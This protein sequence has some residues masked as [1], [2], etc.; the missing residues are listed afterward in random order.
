MLSN[1]WDV[2]VVGGGLAG[3]VISSR[4][5]Q[6]NGALRILLVEAGED[7]S[8]NTI[9]PYANN[10]A[11]LVPSPWTWNDT[12]T[13]QIGLDNRVLDQPAG[14]GLGGGTIVNSCRSPAAQY[15]TN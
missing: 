13:A 15:S 14:K 10:Q 1:L 3:S 9:I 11:L 12:T 6:G 4:L 8:N 2:I 7:V 5:I